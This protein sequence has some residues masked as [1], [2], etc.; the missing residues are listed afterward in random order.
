MSWAMIDGWREDFNE[1]PYDYLAVRDDWEIFC[2]NTSQDKYR[3]KQ[4]NSQITIYCN[5]LNEA[6]E[7][8][9]KNGCSKP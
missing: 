2:K 3:V 5:T 9:Y 7:H 4:M 6:K 1:G 8:A